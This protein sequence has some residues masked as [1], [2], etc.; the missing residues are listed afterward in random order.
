VVAYGSIIEGR[1]SRGVPTAVAGAGGRVKRVR[2]SEINQKRLGWG[3]VAPCLLAAF[4][5]GLVLP[6][7]TADDDGAEPAGVPVAVVVDMRPADTGTPFVLAPAER[8]G[9]VSVERREIERGP[10]RSWV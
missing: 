6:F 4:L 8:A 1:P 9:A 5:I 3:V 7:Y 2:R 10:P